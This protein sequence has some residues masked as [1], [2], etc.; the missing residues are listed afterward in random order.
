MGNKSNKPKNDES[1]KKEIK[2]ILVGESGVGKTNLIN[3]TVGLKFNPDQFTTSVHSFSKM[4]LKYNKNDYILQIWDTIG[5]EKLRSLNNLFFN[6]TKIVIFVY[7]ICT[8]ESLDSL[9]NYWIK[10]INEKLGTSIIK[11]ICGNKSDLYLNQEVSEKEGSELADS[12]G[13]NLLKQQLKMIH[14]VLFIF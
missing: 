13:Q 5:Q 4:P 12:I 6:D 14:I 3:V 2:I 11:G 8:R 7:D 9:K 1:E 10:E